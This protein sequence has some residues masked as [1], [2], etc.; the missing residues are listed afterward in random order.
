[1]VIANADYRFIEVNQAF[2]EFLGYTREELLKKTILEVTYKEDVGT[3]SEKLKKLFTGTISDFRIEKRYIRKDGEIVWGVVTSSQSQKDDEG[4]ALL[5]FAVIADITKQKKLEEALKKSESSY[6]SLVDLSPDGVLLLDIEKI[7]FVN[8]VGI[9]MLGAKNEHDLIGKS[10]FNFVHPENVSEVKEKI[11]RTVVQGR[12]IPLGREKF[13]RLDGQV[14]ELEMLSTPILFGGAKVAQV[15]LHDVT[16]RIEVERK[17]KQDFSA[18]KDS[19]EKLRREKEFSEL[20]INSLPGIYYLFD[21]EGHYVRWNQNLIKVGGYSVE[22]MLKLSPVDFFTAE[23]KPKIAEKIKETFTIGY[24]EVEA[25]LVTKG[26]NK[27]PFYFN[28]ARIVVDGEPMVSGMG[29][30]ITDRKKAELELVEGRA[31]LEAILEGIGEGVFVV[32]ELGRVILFNRA[33]ARITGYTFGDVVSKNYWEVFH[34]STEGLTQA[35]NDFVRQ[36]LSN[37]QL[38]EAANL[39]F[40]R[41]NIKVPV[42]ANAAPVFGREKNLL[43]IVVVFRDVSAQREV[44]RIRDEFMMIASHELRA[45]MTAIKWL[46]SMVLEGSYGPID[47]GMKTPLV[48]VADSTG[49]LIHLVNDLIS[50]TRIEGGELKY[51]FADIDIK[52]LV[53]SLVIT[54]AS[55]AMGKGVA[56]RAEITPGLMVQVDSDRTEQVLAN[57]IDNAIKFNREGGEVILTAQKHDDFVEIK[58]ADTGVGIPD[59]FRDKLFTKFSQIINKKEGRPGG[60]GLGLFISRELA[61][62]MG[63]ELTLTESEMGRGSSFVLSL[64]ATGSKAASLALKAM[65]KTE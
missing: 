11:E 19:E 39:I 18:L 28:G 50:V 53:D 25:N 5:T 16:D 52:K 21:S 4:K 27:I 3:S 44:E 32:D 62:G 57:L 49:R 9:Q 24:S 13:M 30:D 31:R 2:C 20:L 22:E 37:K 36:A 54:F 33:A 8:R 41:G 15:V 42:S 58:M 64:P 61:R 63:G 40:S 38:V 45:P 59:H 14:A 23:E 17:A 47:E 65:R 55:E 43:G 48:G 46:V 60:T 51:S 10:V 34:F 29:I 56:L 12:L 7:I 6:H 35:K 26:G 1:M